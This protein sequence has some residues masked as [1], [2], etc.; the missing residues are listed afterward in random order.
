[1][2]RLVEKTRYLRFNFLQNISDFL[3]NI[4]F[5]FLKFVR[6]IYHGLS[7]PKKSCDF[8]PIYPSLQTE[9]ISS[10]YTYDFNQDP[11][12]QTFDIKRK[13]DE[14]HEAM[15][16]N[17]SFIQDPIASNTQIL[18]MPLR[19]PQILHDFPTKTFLSLMEN[20]KTLQL[21]NIY[22]F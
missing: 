20:L 14:P 22:R 1:M 3:V 7:H 16:E 12:P 4:S 8:T 6:I 19:L 2:G 18:Y 17:T 21:R 15:S 10:S 13:L 11:S 5:S 9:S